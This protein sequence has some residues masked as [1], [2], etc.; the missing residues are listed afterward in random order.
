MPIV[1]VNY[2]Q[3]KK[4]SMASGFYLI[5]EGKTVFEVYYINQGPV[6]FKSIIRKDDNS[7]AFVSGLKDTI[8]IMNP[9]RETDNSEELKKISKQIDD[10][11]RAWRMR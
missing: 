9:I 8:P 6:I 2:N 10:F 4:M 11:M 1:E 5:W 3:L 7:L